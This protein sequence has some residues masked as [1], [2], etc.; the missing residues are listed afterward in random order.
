MRFSIP[1]RS[2]R[3]CYSNLIPHVFLLLISNDTENAR[4]VF[5]YISY[6]HWVSFLF[7]K[8][9]FGDF[10]HFITQIL[11]KFR[12]LP[13]PHHSPPDFMPLCHIK[14]RN[15]S[16][17][18]MPSLCRGHANLCIAPISI[19]T[20]KASTHFNFFNSI[21]CVCVSIGCSYSFP[22]IHYVSWN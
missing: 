12:S 20:T 3:N 11:I 7:F 8:S 22:S 19:C 2:L 9:I 1:S 18:C 15:I 6:I 14:I 5:L 4:V 13:H 21:L 10:L 16:Q 17:I